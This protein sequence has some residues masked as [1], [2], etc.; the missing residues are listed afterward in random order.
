M[1]RWIGVYGASGFGREVMPLVA[2]TAPN[3]A[4]L[5]FVDDSG[6]GSC[7]GYDILSFKQFS[8]IDGPRAITIAIADARVRQQLAAKCEDAGITP[9]DVAA[10]N[11][12]IGDAVKLGEGSI[13]CSFV[14]LT[15]NVLIGAYF[16]ANIYSYVAHDCVIGDYVTFAPGVKCNGNVHISDHAYVGTGAILKQGQPSKPLRIGKGATV[17]MGAVVTKDVG[18]GETVIGNPARIFERR[19]SV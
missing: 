17:G 12:V 13:L 3:D 10:Q 4:R 1:A 19:N 11:L 16:H 18:D 15:S 2:K 6:V 14:H 5:V 8:E 9:F 7:N